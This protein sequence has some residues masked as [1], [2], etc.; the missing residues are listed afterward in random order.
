MRQIFFPTKGG[1]RAAERRA[2]EKHAEEMK[3]LRMERERREQLHQMFMPRLEIFINQ[4]MRSMGV[5]PITGRY[6]L[7]TAQL[8]Q[9]GRSGAEVRKQTAEAGLE[10]LSQGVDPQ[11][12]AK[13]QHNAEM[14]RQL[15]LSQMAAEGKQQSL[16]NSYNLIMGA[17]GNQPVQISPASSYSIPYS[18]QPSLLQT[19][20]QAAGAYMQYEQMRKYNRLLDEMYKQQRAQNQATRTQPPPQ[21]G[22]SPV[23]P[24]LFNPGT[25]V[26]L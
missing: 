26:G 4:T 23:P 24:Y 13:M 10:L 2:E 25:S 11:T 14:Q 1:K 22:V 21:V 5:D 19:A 7:P 18:Q 15:Q 3:L 9:L 17:M 6:T 8:M 16:L 12:V 20:A